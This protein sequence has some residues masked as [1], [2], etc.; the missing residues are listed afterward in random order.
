V[1]L[2]A[3]LGLAFATAPDF[4]IL[5][6]TLHTS[7]SSVH[8]AKGTQSPLTGLLQLVSIWFQGLLTPLT[9]VLF[10]FPSRYWFTIGYQRVFSLRRWSSQIHTDFQVDCATWVL[11]EHLL[12]FVYGSITLYG[13]TSQSI[14]LSKRTFPQPTSESAMLVP[15][16][17]LHNAL[18]LTCNEF[19]LFPLRSPLLGESFLLS[20][21]VVTKMFQFATLSLKSV[22]A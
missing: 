16:P 15:L 19:G 21:P 3:Q 20:F 7:N 2:N 8:Y 1:Q 22:R 9:G 17:P 14:R 12:D 5:N 6:L 11:T 18:T 13:Y 10:T 4:R